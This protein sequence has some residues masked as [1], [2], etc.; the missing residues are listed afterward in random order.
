MTEKDIVKCRTYERASSPRS[1]NQLQCRS[2][3]VITE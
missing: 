2:T 3:L 1:N